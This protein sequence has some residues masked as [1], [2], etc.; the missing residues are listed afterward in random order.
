MYTELKY[1]S[2]DFIYV[3]FRLKVIIG[4]IIMST[5]KRLINITKSQYFNA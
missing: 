4:G 2:N 3:W 1:Y 5:F